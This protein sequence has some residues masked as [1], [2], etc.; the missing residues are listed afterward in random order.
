MENQQE[1]IM[2]KLEI[3]KDQVN[4]ENDILVDLND[5]FVQSLKD[6]VMKY[7][8]VVE[9]FGEYIAS[10]ILDSYEK[11]IQQRK[12]CIDKYIKFYSLIL[13]DGGEFDIS[14]PIKSL[15]EKQQ[16]NID[17]WQQEMI[18]LIELRKMRK[19]YDIPPDEKANDVIELFKNMWL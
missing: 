4:M 14:N 15:M 1:D 2:K 17:E 12:E 16:S 7:G 9:D 8:N 6:I 5:Q 18:P 3:V 19:K 10:D 13:Q 11:L